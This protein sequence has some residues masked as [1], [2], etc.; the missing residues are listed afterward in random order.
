MTFYYNLG[1]ITSLKGHFWRGN[2]RTLVYPA[3]RN[4]EVH[5]LERVVLELG[6][7]RSGFCALPAAQPEIVRLEKF[8]ELE[9][10]RNEIV[11][12]EPGQRVVVQRQEVF[13]LK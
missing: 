1:L 13:I 9:F 6:G 4:K 5:L 2:T 12:A 8:P 3:P 10:G 7:D 11:A